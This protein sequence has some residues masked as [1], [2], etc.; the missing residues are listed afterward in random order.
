MDELLQIETSQVRTGAGVGTLEWVDELKYS[1]ERSPTR[2]LELCAPELFYF[3]VRHHVL[4]PII[5]MALY[6]PM[7]QGEETKDQIKL[8]GESVAVCFWKGRQMPYARLSRRLP[9]MNKNTKDA[10]EKKI[11]ERVRLMLFF[12][13]VAEVDDCKFKARSAFEPGLALTWP[14]PSLTSATFHAAVQRR[15]RGAPEPREAEKRRAR[16]GSIL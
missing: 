12:G 10:E 1:L 14:L 4:G 3:R 9:F 16:R 8:H 5:G 11:K 6:M 2:L 7:A 13:T 15:H